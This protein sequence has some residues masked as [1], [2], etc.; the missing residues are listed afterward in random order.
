MLVRIH[1]VGFDNRKKSMVAPDGRPAGLG[2]FYYY[3]SDSV[4]YA[5][6]RF[7]T[8][9]H[10]RDDSTGLRIRGGS[11]VARDARSRW[12]CGI[13]I[14]VLL[15]GELEGFLEGREPDVIRGPEPATESEVQYEI[16]L[17]NLLN[18]HDWRQ[19]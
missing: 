3:E 12:P 18:F 10:G 9:R 6:Q 4:R 13:D 15:P 5:V 17:R 11:S 7:W 1:Y 2:R 19:G 16:F 14:P 8:V